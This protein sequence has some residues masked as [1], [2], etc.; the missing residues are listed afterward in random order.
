MA[1][2]TTL[3]L[4]GRVQQALATVVEMGIE[5]HYVSVIIISFYF[6]LMKMGVIS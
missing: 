1:V 2:A 3:L 4:P 5:Y 6:F